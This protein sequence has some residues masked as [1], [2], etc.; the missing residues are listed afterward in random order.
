VARS[1]RIPRAQLNRRTRYEALVNSRMCCQE[2]TI[3]VRIDPGLKNGEKVPRQ[4][5]SL[6]IF[7]GS[8]YRVRRKKRPGYRVFDLNIWAANGPQKPAPRP[9]TPELSLA[10]NPIDLG[11]LRLLSTHIIPSHVST[12]TS[13]TASTASWPLVTRLPASKVM[14]IRSAV[15]SLLS[16][17]LY[18]TMPPESDIPSVSFSS[19][20][21]FT[22]ALHTHS[23]VPLF[24][25]IA[26]PFSD[27]FILATYIPANRFRTLRFRTPSQRSSY[28]HEQFKDVSG[29]PWLI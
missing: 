2:A 23:F 20:L 3:T 18:A 8:T 27:S 13:S 7:N 6:P 15:I 22:S 24:E 9:P 1:I 10:L 19:R 12:A 21:Q 17:S 29:I 5:V 28:P 11:I 25:E 26:P 4:E 16:S 14:I